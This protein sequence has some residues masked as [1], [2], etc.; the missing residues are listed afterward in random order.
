MGGVPW[1]QWVAGYPERSYMVCLCYPQTSV[2]FRGST[3]ENKRIL[4]IWKCLKQ[5]QG[6]PDNTSSSA[7]LALLGII[8]IEVT[9]HK[10]LLNIFVNMI[11]LDNSVELELAHRQLVM[12]DNPRESIFTHIKSILKHYGL[13]S[14][15][16]LISSPPSKAEWKSTL[17][18]KIHDM[19]ESAWNVDI[20]SKSSTKYVNP[21]VLKVGSCHHVW[22]TVRDNIH[23]SKRAQIKCKLLTGTYILQANRAAFNQYA[24]NATCKL[25]QSAPETRQ[26][27]IGVCRIQG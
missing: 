26:H 25:C 5:L 19:V 7:C 9:L 24:V 4:S 17:N 15:F 6:L 20:T 3:F 11:K 21:D 2:R 16:S 1:G 18:H 13:P 27:F 14:V 10:N 8:P 12:K 23:D 22:S